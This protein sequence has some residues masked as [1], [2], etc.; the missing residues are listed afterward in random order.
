MN[1]VYFQTHLLIFPSNFRL[2]M[3]QSNHSFADKMIKNQELV[4]IFY[5]YFYPIFGLSVDLIQL[6]MSLCQHTSYIH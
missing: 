4:I 3:F 2:V 1:G 6:L 5:L